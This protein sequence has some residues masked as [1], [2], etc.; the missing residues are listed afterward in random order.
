[1]VL[2][3]YRVLKIVFFSLVS[4]IGN[5]QVVFEKDNSCTVDKRIQV[6]MAK[7]RQQLM[8]NKTTSK[9]SKDKE[10]EGAFGKKMGKT[11]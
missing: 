9:N 1:M 6:L 11:L 5:A 7:L 10:N 4:L 3:S 2:N 8:L